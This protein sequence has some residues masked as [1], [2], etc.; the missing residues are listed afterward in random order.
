MIADGFFCV[1]FR[2]LSGIMKLKAAALS[3]FIGEKKMNDF[4]TGSGRE[5]REQ[6][7]VEL[8]SEMYRNVTMGSEN[9]AAVVPRV[10]DKELMENVTAQLENYADF[11]RRTADLL[12]KRSIT[13]KEPTLMKKAMSR[14]GIMLNA[15]IDPSKEHIAQMIAKGTETGADQLQLKFER[16][17]DRG[18]SDDALCLCGEILAFERR[19]IARANNLREGRGSAE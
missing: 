1:F 8:L 4:F 11:T 9:L 15:M 2:T 6:V 7:T 3:I 12:S 16:F 19:E 18:C 14:G 10:R 13:P 5:K 17:R